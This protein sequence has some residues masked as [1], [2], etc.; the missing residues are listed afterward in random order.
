LKRV[1]NL[2]LLVLSVF[3]DIEGFISVNWLCDVS[4]HA[5]EP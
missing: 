2:Q 1:R 3:P 4:L 5:Y